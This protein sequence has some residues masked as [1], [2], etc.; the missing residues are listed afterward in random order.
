MKITSAEF[1]TGAVSYKQYPDSAYP[2]LAFAGRSNVG[3][4]SLINS[5]LNRKKLVKTSQTPGKTQEINF[6]KINND[7]IFTDLPGYG[8]A[9]VP[10]PVRKRW[11]KMIEDYLLK[12]ETLLAVIFIIDLRRRPSQLDLSL[13]RWLE[14][15]GVEYLLVGTKMDKLSQS[16]IKKQ[17]DKLNVA[18]FDGGEGE[19]LVYSSKSSRGRKELWSKIT[20]RLEEFKRN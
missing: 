10:Q 14:A 3:K 19:L 17:K 5:L 12:R 13:Q 7:F 8:F 4:S 15:H 11:G 2:E 18:Y 20:S 9:K 16:E 1:L 6:F